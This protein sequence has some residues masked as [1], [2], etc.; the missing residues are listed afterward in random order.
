MRRLLFILGTYLLPLTSFPLT[1]LP[2]AF[3]LSPLAHAQT[4]RYNAQRPLVMVCDWDKPPYEFLNDKGEPAGSNIDIMRAVAKEIGIPIRFVMKEWSI[5]IKTFERGDADIIIANARRYQ[6]SEYIGSENTI[7]YYR[8]RAAVRGDSVGRLSMEVLESEGAVFKPG[9]FASVY[10]MGRETG[11]QGDRETGRRIEFQTPKVAL[12]G[13]INGDYK[14]FI[15]GEEPLKWKIKELN[16]EGISLADADIPISEHHVF[17]RDRELMTQIDDQY[18]RLKQQGVIATIQDR[19][20]HPERR[21]ERTSHTSIYIAIAILIAAALLYLLNRVARRH[22]VSATRQSRE[23]NEMMLQALH[24][25]SFIVMEYDIHHDRV[26]N[27]YGHI[28]PDEGMHLEEFINRIH[29]DQRQEFRQR[30]KALIEGRERHFELDK[31]WNAGSDEEFRWFNFRGHAIVELDENGHPAYVVNAIHNATQDMEEDQAARELIQKY[32]ILSNLPL[33]A[34]SFYNKEGFLIDLND[35]MKKLCGMDRDLNASRFWDTVSMFDVP[36]FRNVIS[37]S[38]REDVHFCQLMEYPELGIDR[39]IECHINPLFN[40]E[41][42]ISNYLVIA[43]DITE[44]R[45]QTHQLYQMRK[46]EEETGVRKQETGEQLKDMLC[47]SGRHILR[48]DIP[49]QAIRLFRSPEEPE[50]VYTFTGLADMLVEEDREPFLNIV[51]DTTTRELRNIVVHF[52]QETGDW[53]QGDGETRRQGDRETVVDMTLKPLT[54]E[55]DQ[56]IGHEGVA[57]DITEQHKTRQELI[58]TTQRAK[59]SVRLKSGFMASMTHEL[60]TP[61]NAIVGFTG[62]L[63]A[64]AD[65]PERGEYVRIIRNSSDMLQ[66]LINDIIEA[67]SLADGDI[68]IRPERVDFSAAFDDMCLMLEQRVQSGEVAFEKDNPYTSFLTVVDAERMQQVLTNFV[69]NA[70][71][72]TKKGHIRVG[73]RF[74][75]SRSQGDEETR[76]QGDEETRSQGDEETGSQGDRSQETGRQGDGL[77]LYCEDTGSGIPKEKQQMVF[78]R[79]V[80]LDEFVQGTGMGLAISK[81]IVKSCRGEIGVKSDGEGHG[82]TFWAWIPC[83]RLSA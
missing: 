74:V 19:W 47:D 34:M 45:E 38:D 52:R 22:V 46:E 75:E 51:R 36:L 39:Y 10:L 49:S 13:L 50:F 11:R 21:P 81:A 63:E 31:R 82:S 69:T 35:N 37:P 7:N 68:S 20:I 17:G 66:R 27:N 62:V 4:D 32:A 73:Y 59:D 24:M 61:L 9:E 67:S 70:V 58:K 5:A 79:F 14:Y 33:V 6:K 16:L 30:S 48:S 72:F 41:G 40:A 71:K 2:V 57:T 28:L 55:H 29:P 15:W 60:R 43:L 1:R 44:S 26:T 78:E 56:I 42:D 25:G 8:I 23:L 54:D 53:S 65:S 83:E 77:Y 3:H 76:S 80:K 12:M 64:L 18:S